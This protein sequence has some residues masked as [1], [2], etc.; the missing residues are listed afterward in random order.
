MDIRRR[1]SDAL[2]EQEVARR[3]D[4]AKQAFLDQFDGES[5]RKSM[6]RDAYERL[7]QLEKQLLER[8]PERFR[9]E[10]EVRTLPRLL[11]QAEEEIREAMR[12]ELEPS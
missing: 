1:M 3:L 2:L 4:K 6:D 12:E 10:F 7:Q 8:N 5:L 9:V 11:E